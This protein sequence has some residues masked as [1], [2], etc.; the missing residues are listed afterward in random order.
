M[1]QYDLDGFTIH[2]TGADGKPATETPINWSHYAALIAIADQQKSAASINTN[3]QGAYLNALA[4][5]ARAPEK[6]VPPVKPTMIVVNDQGAESRVAFVPPL[7]DPVAFNPVGSGSSVSAPAPD[8]LDVIL[9]IVM[10]Q[11]KL[12]SKIA[13]Q[14]EVG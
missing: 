8:R 3:A 1:I 14:L 7:P 4:D 2:Y 13:A 10:A 12:I 6:G 5:Y 11:S 9:S